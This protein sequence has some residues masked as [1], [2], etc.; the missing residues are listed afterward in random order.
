MKNYNIVKRILSAVLCVILAVS[1]LPVGAM[2][3]ELHELDILDDV[4]A[5]VET[6]DS[7]LVKEEAE[8]TAEESVEL[9]EATK[10]ENIEE[11]EVDGEPEIEEVVE[12]RSAVVNPLYQDILTEEDILASVS[13]DAPTLSNGATYTDIYSAADYLRQQMVARTENIVIQ[14]QAEL[15]DYDTEASEL[16]DDI[17]EESLVHTGVPTEG[18]YLRGQLGGWSMSIYASYTDSAPTL[19]DMTITYTPVYFTTADQEADV[20][21]R[22]NSLMSD[23]GFTDSTTEYEK[24]RDIYAWICNAVAYD[25]AHFAECINSCNNPSAH[26]CY[27]ALFEG[28]AVCQGYAVLFY[29]LALEAGLDA[30]YVDGLATSGG[31]SSGHAWNIVSLD[32][33]W[34]LLDVTWD[35]AQT[36]D[37]YQWFLKG[38]E[39]FADHYPYTGQIESYPLS[40]TSYEIPQED[41][42]PRTEGDYTYTVLAGEATITAYT[43]TE[44]DVVVPAT[45]G[46]YPVTAVGWEAFS[47]NDTMETL[48]FSEGLETLSPFSIRE[49]NQ[50]REVYLPSTV[51]LHVDVGN[52][53]GVDGD[54]WIKWCPKLE[55][56]EVSQE[57]TNITSLDGILYSKDMTWLLLYPA[58]ISQETFVVPDGVK[59]LR[60]ESCTGNPYVKEI[61]LP[62]GLTIIGYWSFVNCYSLERINIPETCQFIGQYIIRQTNI[63]TLHIP[64]SVTGIAPSAFFQAQKL[65]SISVDKNNPVYYVEDGVLFCHGEDAEYLI[66]YPAQKENSSYTIPEGCRLQDSCFYGA[67]NLETVQFND[68]ITTIPYSTFSGCSN[69]KYIVLP[70]TVISIEDSA[71]FDCTSLATVQIPASVTSIGA[72]V[73]A[74]LKSFVIFGEV[75]SYAEQ[76]A[77]EN[78]YTFCEIGTEL[79]ASGSCGENATWSL[80][81]GVL[82][83]QGSGPMAD[84]TWDSSVPWYSL[85]NLIETVII[86]NGITA[87]GSNAFNR[88]VNLQHVEIPLSVNSINWASFK[89]CSGLKEIALPTEMK[90][91]SGYAFA[92]CTSLKSITIP[93]N[94]VVETCA[95][96][97][98]TSLEKIV[99]EDGIPSVELKYIGDH[100]FRECTSLKTVTI[101]QSIIIISENAFYNCTSL[102]DVRYSGTEE[103][104]NNVQMSDGNECL[105]PIQFNARPGDVTGDGSVGIFDLVELMKAVT[106]DGDAD[107]LM[108]NA[109]LNSDGE[110]DILDVIRFVRYLAGHKVDL[111]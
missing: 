110:V 30:R 64:A 11:D 34:Y 60:D 3:L 27:N 76:Y 38:T 51:I 90:C 5:A 42:S 108:H 28:T 57:N 22:I 45:L 68:T 19:Y 94:A 96:E 77:Q 52:V 4:V 70:D 82:T 98:C 73:F 48:S 74:N 111:F 63:Q 95:F 55:K 81:D 46:G 6:E 1:M 36:A 7:I 71:F 78:G 2:A 50:L 84:Y 21:A 69:L 72:Y 75:G 54:Q 47:Y 100:A 20:T 17:W 102:T 97:Y 40:E 86:E 8:E 25:Y 35:E 67:A 99:F 14:Y 37:S 32:G 39:D 88:C 13:Y 66:C 93:Y 15:T 33:A 10:E 61:I 43:G 83:V 65:E 49:C 31:L 56:I 44:K 89:R 87:I 104:W 80:K 29:R 107:I 23:F 109:D 16:A 58:G 18:D 26:S 101:S 106:T 91:L 41:N 59:R 9:A 103:D 105:F 92:N 85:R 79:E 24:V 12:I 62:E 53:A